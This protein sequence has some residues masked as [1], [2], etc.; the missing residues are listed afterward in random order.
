MAEAN[1]KAN[2]KPFF[3]RIKKYFKDTKAEL[4][5]VTWPT[6]EKLKQNTLVILAFI[7]MACVFL[8]VCD[9]VFAKLF[10]VLTGMLG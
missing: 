3:E 2:K 1:V 7:I 10:S 5:K 9:L 4:K 8:S 6:K